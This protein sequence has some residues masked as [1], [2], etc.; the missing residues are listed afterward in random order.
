LTV[1]AALAAALGAGGCGIGN[2]RGTNYASVQ[3]TSDFGSHVLGRAIQTHVP[4]SETS[5]ALTAR[6]FKVTRAADG[7]VRTIGGHGE[8]GDAQWFGYINGIKPVAGVTPTYVH[9]GDHVWWDLH[10]A[11]AAASIPAVVGAFPEPFTSGIGGKQ[12]PTVLDCAN[13]VQKA[14]NAV[15]ASLRKAGVKVSFQLLGGGSGSDS[16]AV[17]VGTW[18]DLKGVIA[19]ELVAGGPAHSGVYARFVGSTG[20]AIELENAAGDV[21]RTLHGSAGMVAATEQISLSQPTW[22]VTGTNVA[23]VAEAAKAFTA[24]KLRNHFAVTMQQ[25]A[26]IPIPITSGS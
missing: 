18:N 21:V 10:D 15:G 19:A 25:G 7:A 4:G 6:H 1:F 22:L 16:L 23:G 2:A 5:V 17:V 12:F 14:C 13:N 11:S 20:Q 26:V 24:A 9:K 3:V 8:A